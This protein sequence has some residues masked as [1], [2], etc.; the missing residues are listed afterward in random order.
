MAAQGIWTSINAERSYPFFA[1]LHL[2]ISIF[3][4]DSSKGT[5]LWGVGGGGGVKCYELGTINI[6]LWIANVRADLDRS[7][8]S[9]YLRVIPFLFLR[10]TTCF[11]PS[12]LPPS[13]SLPSFIPSPCSLGSF[14]GILVSQTRF[15]LFRGGKFLGKWIMWNCFRSDFPTI[16]IKFYISR[17]LKN[18]HAQK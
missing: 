17:Y 6:V 11:P 4:K 10:A 18:A 15:K 7:H 9:T 2:W 12:P 16:K 5:W 1:L 14:N 3:W 13:P 8:L